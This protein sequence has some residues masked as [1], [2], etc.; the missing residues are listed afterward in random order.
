L[1]KKEIIE[2]GW[3]EKYVLG[4][5]TEEESS[6]VERMAVLYPE[7]QGSIN[8]SRND[9]CGKFNRSLT[10]P[11][12][13]NA[14]MNKRKLMI[15]TVSIVSLFSLGFCFLCREHFTMKAVVSEQTQ[16]LALEQAKVSQLVSLTK[17]RSIFLH[18][19]STRRIKLKGCADYPDA[20]VMVFQCVKTGRMMLRVIDLPELPE[21]Q[22]YEVRAQQSDQQ[23]YLIGQLRPPLRFDSLYVLDSKLLCS[24]L[25][26][27]S[28]D[29]VSHTSMP[30]CL[31]DLDKK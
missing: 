26:I 4:L 8:I 22:Y 28:I 14:F 25:E 9:I 15:L 1:T 29:P 16:K 24:E 30:I 10:Q 6:E 2:N 13:R 7:I 20:E 23:N 21:G 18:A 12:L 19:P 5:T 27:N 3:V 17:E 31:A 11:A